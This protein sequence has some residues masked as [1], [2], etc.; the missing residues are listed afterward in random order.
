MYRVARSGIVVFEPQETLMTRIGV[1]LGV[2][3]QYECAA[4]ADHDMRWGGVRNTGIPN[5]VYR[6]TEREIRKVLAAYDTTGDPRLRCFYDLRVPD[7]SAA[8]MRSQ[9]ARLAAHVA[10]PAARLLLRL[11]PSQANA[12]AVV[13]DKLDPHAHLHPWLSLDEDGVRADASW[14]AARH[15]RSWTSDPSTSRVCD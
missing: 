1:R 4:V 2:G 10:V 8:G 7:R 12:I 6:W 14:F 11:V 13:A 3:Q 9:P 5:F 15:A